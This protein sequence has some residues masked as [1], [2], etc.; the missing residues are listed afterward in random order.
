[1]SNKLTVSWTKHLSTPE[2]KERFAQF[3]RSSGPVLDRLAELLTDKRN[4]IEVF[5]TEDYKDGSWAYRAADRNGYVRAIDEI[6]DI[7]TKGRSV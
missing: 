6:I 3:V 4:G 7:I 5:G 2:E 1:M